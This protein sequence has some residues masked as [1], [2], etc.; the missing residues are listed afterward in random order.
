MTIT[1]QTLSE[2]ETLRKEHL[3]SDLITL[4]A[5]QYGLAAS[6]AM[7]LYYSSQLSQ[8]VA[9]GSYGIEQLDAHY[10]LSDLQQYEPQ[11]FDGTS[12]SKTQRH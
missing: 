6:D 3:E 7:K 4:I 2:L 10:L 9:E 1:P 8:Q 12:V 5:E 11:L